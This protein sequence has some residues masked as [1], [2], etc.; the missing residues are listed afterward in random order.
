MNLLSK[1]KKLNIP[2]SDL[3]EKSIR[4]KTIRSK[5]SLE[6][7][8][9]ASWEGQSKFFHGFECE[10]KIFLTRIKTPI[11]RFLFPKIIVEFDENDFSNYKL[12]LSKLSYLIF[13]LLMGLISM[14]LFYSL[15]SWRLESDILEMI[16]Y[17][18]L[19]VCFGKIDMFLVER[20]LKQSLNFD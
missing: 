19:F 1:T 9:P 11:E 4:E 5:E 7:F 15:F 13:V 2:N 6:Y 17:G 10:H 18:V 14:N 16:F 8:S 12:R 20:K 3:I